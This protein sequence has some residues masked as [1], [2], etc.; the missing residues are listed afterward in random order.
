M[1]LRVTHNG[2]TLLGQCAEEFDSTLQVLFDL[3]TSHMDRGA[4]LKDGIEVAFGWTEL[5][6][7]QNGGVFEFHEPDFDADPS[8][9]S[10]ENLDVSLSGY[11]RQQLLIDALGLGRWAPAPYSDTAHVE[12]GAF[13]ASRITTK[14]LRDPDGKSIW[15]VCTEATARAKAEITIERLQNSF[16]QVPIWHIFDIRPALFDSLALPVGFQ[17]LI[18]DDRIVQIASDDGEHWG[19]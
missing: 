3:M 14:R 1:S 5:R 10:R 4:V 15:L 6:I 8:E 7:K 16:E 12:N 18:D 13:A 11:R 19:L 17:A 2:V 9:D